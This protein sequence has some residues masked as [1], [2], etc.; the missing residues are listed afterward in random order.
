MTAP[1]HTPLAPRPSAAEET[2]AAVASGIAG[3]LSGLL[4]ALDRLDALEESAFP[5]WRATGGCSPEELRSAARELLARALRVAAD[6]HAYAL[7]EALCREG[8]LTVR[9]AMAWT[10]SGRLVATER[11]R[12]LVLAGLAVGDPGF[13]TVEPSPAGQALYALLDRS[14]ALAVEQALGRASGGLA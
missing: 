1:V 12:D 2:A 10:G 5:D 6:P 14:V 11:L 3:R 7:L 8:C 4:R 9:Q 13:G